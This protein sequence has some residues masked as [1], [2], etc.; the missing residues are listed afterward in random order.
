ML[1]EPGTPV[2]PEVIE[3]VGLKHLALEMSSVLDMPLTDCKRMIRMLCELV[4]V[5]LEGGRNVHLPGLGKFTTNNYQTFYS[6]DPKTGLVI[7]DAEGNPLK[8]KRVALVR[9]KLS[10]NCKRR[11]HTERPLSQ[12]ELDQMNEDDDED[13]DDE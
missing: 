5:H 3:Y 10:H 6:R 7:K 2:I 12:E 11:V 8:T 9:F 1:F 13:G 4:T